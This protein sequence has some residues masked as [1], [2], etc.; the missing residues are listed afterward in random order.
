MKFLIT[1]LVLLL[2]MNTHATDSNSTLI[3]ESNFQELGKIMQKKSLGLVLMIHAENCP[4][5]ALM[6][7]E[8]LSP[9]V[10]SGD[11][12]QKVILRKLQI[13]DSRNVTDFSGAIV[14]PADIADRYKAS[15]TPTLVFLDYQGKQVLNNMIG[16]NTVELFGAYLDIEIDK[17][18]KKIRKK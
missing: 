7:A 18:V 5:C 6:E 2:S 4:Y 1:T 3:E 12:D 13:D 11:Y 16:I 8:I 10:I 14:T 17:L 9:M 15:L